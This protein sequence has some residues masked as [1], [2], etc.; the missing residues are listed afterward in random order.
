MSE[1]PPSNSIPR[2]L[3]DLLSA[4]PA[5]LGL[6]LVLHFVLQ[7]VLYLGGRLGAETYASP[8]IALGAFTNLRLFVPLLLLSA[9]FAW[10][11]RELGWRSLDEGGYPRIVVFPALLVLTWSFATLEPN[12]FFDQVYLVDRVLLVAAAAFTLYHPAGALPFVLMVVAIGGQW[13]HPLPYGSW[14]WV[15]KRLPLD[16]LLVVVG[17]LVLR[18][19]LRERTR[20]ELL[21]T[22][23]LVM[24]GST[25]FH[26]GL[27]KLLLGPGPQAWLFD[28]DLS[29]LF[30]SAHLAGGWLRHLPQDE[31]LAIAA[32][33]HTLRIPLALATMGIELLGIALLWRSRLTRV[34]IPLFVLLHGAI[35]A[36]SGIFFW[37]WMVTDLALLA[38]LWTLDRRLS[39][40]ARDLY[41]PKQAVVAGVAILFGRFVFADMG[42]SWF[43]SNLVNHFEIRAE[44]VS[45]KSY[46]IDARFF[47]PYDILFQQSRHYYAAPGAVVVGTYGTTELYEV[48]QDLRSATPDT[49]PAIRERWARPRPV[50]PELVNGL[51]DFVAR[52]IIN[53]HLR[54]EPPS[55]FSAWSP[56]FHFQTTL[57][58]NAFVGQEPLASF[59]IHFVEYLHHAASIEKT[60]D[61]LVARVMLGPPPPTP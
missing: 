40:T 2:R 31:I 49:M 25:Y 20:P 38:Y 37:K 60:R 58:D 14:Q 5:Q 19:G 43:D 10:R 7:Q 34:A 61:D 28:N 24:V 41:G 22:M 55:A 57:P 23:L 30:V 36:T 15:D 8:V 3:R 29:N 13:H 52:S 17:Y 48:M 44:G 53:R 54:G 47:A 50:S 12:P 27:N 4:L 33:L 39:E 6:F 32:R 26:A 16:L 46:Q 11:F 59:E 21:P 1:A 9:L 42:F 51:V 56:P 35:L 18:S 45:G